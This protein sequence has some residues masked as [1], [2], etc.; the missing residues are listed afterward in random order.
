MKQGKYRLLVS[1]VHIKEIGA[2]EDIFERVEL[3]TILEKFGEPVM[4]NMAKSRA[5]AEKLVSL[6]F[7]VADAAHVTFAEQAG[8]LFISCDD[9]L[10]KKCLNHEINVWCGNPVAFC[11]KEELR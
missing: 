3:Q 6:S 5:R 4:V 10:I 2:I 7:G 8:A 1:P 11:E 9:K